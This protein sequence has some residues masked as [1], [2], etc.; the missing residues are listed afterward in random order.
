MTAPSTFGVTYT[1]IHDEFFGHAP[2]FSAN[3]V[4]SSTQ[5]TL[6]IGKRAAKLDGKLRLKGLDPG[7]IDDDSA[8]AAYLWCQ[9]V[10]GLEVAIR[11]VN[12]GIALEPDVVKAWREE[13]K[14]YY[15]DLDERGGAA[16]GSGATLPD[17][18]PNGPSSHIDNN[19]LETEDTD[20]ISPVTHKFRVTDQL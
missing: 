11:C 14:G 18:D 2:N 13:L 10:L 17:E 19:D 1:T 12:A 15:A 4:P 7:Q 3:S 8:S 5:V 9:E 16:L 20:D 6:I